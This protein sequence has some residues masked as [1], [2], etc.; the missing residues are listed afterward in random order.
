MFLVAPPPSPR[1]SK[2]PSP[3]RVKLFY[4]NRNS[5][6]IEI[7]H[8]LQYISAEIAEESKTVILSEIRLIFRP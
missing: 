1:K 2:N 6:S 7:L 5:I 3:N 8:D 4:E